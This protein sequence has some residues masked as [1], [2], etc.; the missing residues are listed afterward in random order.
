MSEVRVVAVNGDVD[1]SR[2]PALRD[3]LRRSVSNHDSGLV[4]DLSPT[5]YL[6][7][8]GVN[9][10]FE[11]AEEL[12]DR[13]LGFAVVVPEGSLVERVIVLVDLAAAAGIH[14]TVDDARRALEP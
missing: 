4:V 10:L 11:V 1:I 3:E 2:A 8:A 6:D 14:R 7:S 12:R 9:T 13:Q 5:T